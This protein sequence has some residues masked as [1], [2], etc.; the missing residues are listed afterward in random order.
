MFAFLT[1][2]AVLYVWRSR[3]STAVL[4]VMVLSAVAALVFLS[5]LAMGTNDAMIRNSVGLFSGHIAG[6]HL[7]PEWNRKQLEVPGVQA[8]LLRRSMPVRLWRQGLVEPVLLF[9]IRPDEEKAHTF[10][11]KKT[12]SGR[13]P[14]PGESVLYLS[15]ATAQRLKARVGDSIRFDIQPGVPGGTL[16]L[17]GIYRTGISALDQGM[18]FCP[19]AA[20]PASGGSL[21]AAV[22]LDDG[23]D[24]KTVLALYRARFGPSP[25]KAWTEFMPDLKQLIDLNFVSMG[26]VMLLVFGV[27]ALGISCAFVIF[28]LKNLREHG[29]MKAM[30]VLPSETAYLLA[31]QV[32]MLTLLASAAGTALGALATASFARIGIDLTSLTSHNPYFAVSGIIYPRLTA[33]SLCLPPLLAVVFG[34][35]AAVWPLIFVVRARAADILR[36]I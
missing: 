3:R 31:A 11:W 15:E 33:Y 27:V 18:A 35:L 6:D 23:V 36:S 29:I 9:G 16:T 24:P 30:G 8:V 32:G 25:L 19:V 5:S 34:Q 10:L 21:S 26:I 13:Y 20:F 14:R 1:R 4:G 17:C 22:F 7:P 2:L 12:V 28:I